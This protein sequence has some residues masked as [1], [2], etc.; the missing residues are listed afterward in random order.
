MMKKH[1]DT[2]ESVSFEVHKYMKTSCEAMSEE[3]I[4]VQIFYITFSWNSV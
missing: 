3:N 1:Y 2:P 4:N